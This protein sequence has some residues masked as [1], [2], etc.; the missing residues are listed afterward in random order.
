MKEMIEI[1]ETLSQVGSKNLS[2]MNAVG[3]EMSKRNKDSR[4]NSHDELST[5]KRVAN[6]KRQ[7][8]SYLYSLAISPTSQDPL[9]PNKLD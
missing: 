5:L 2:P 4:A 1:S 9:S 8:P 7:N 3:M 6:L